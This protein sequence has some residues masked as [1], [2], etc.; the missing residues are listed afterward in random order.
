MS[1]CCVLLP[2]RK[3]CAWGASS[4]V[5]LT[6]LRQGPCSQCQLC[7]ILSNHVVHDSWTVS[8]PAAWSTSVT[9]ASLLGIGPDVLFEF[10]RISF[11]SPNVFEWM[12]PVFDCATTA[13]SM[14]ISSR[15][16]PQVLRVS[17][18]SRL[19]MEGELC[20]LLVPMIP[21]VGILVSLS[22]GSGWVN[23]DLCWASCAPVFT[24]GR[25]GSQVVTASE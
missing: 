5:A 14:W 9:K 18:C 8:M 4:V 25:S 10:R 22:I 3:A 2:M 1:F 13:K 6:F 11:S 7:G 24:C 23:G 16:S 15:L 20:G 21:N 12:C 17:S 19:F